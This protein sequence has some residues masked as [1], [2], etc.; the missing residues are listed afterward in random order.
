MML[1]H[2][3][4]QGNKSLL[5]PDYMFFHFRGSR[6]YWIEGKYELQRISRLWS[7]SDVEMVVAYPSEQEGFLRGRNP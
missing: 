5:P 6:E 7:E 1:D 4:C 2:L 3:T